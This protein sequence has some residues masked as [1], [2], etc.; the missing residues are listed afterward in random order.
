MHE[1]LNGYI[2]TYGYLAIFCL[3]LMQESGVPGLPNEFVLFYF[4]YISHQFHLSYIIVLGL[5]IIA[6]TMGS[7]ILYLLFYHGSN[8]LMQHKPKW[9]RLPVNKILSLLHKVV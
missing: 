7:F 8:W 1:L 6:D 9:L 3:V 4:G 5:V 2:S